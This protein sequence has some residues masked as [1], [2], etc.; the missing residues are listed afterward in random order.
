MRTSTRLMATALLFSLIVMGQ[1]CG[2]PA[3][4]SANKPITL[5]IW[6]TFENEDVLRD[7]M[8]A[9]STL[10]P[11]VSFDYRQK[12]SD[13]YK[14]SLLRAF[15]EGT[16]PDIFSIHNSWIGEYESLM[17][18]MPKTLKIPYTETKGTIKKEKVT[19]I[20]NEPTITLRQLKSEFVDVVTDD[21][22]RSYQATTNDEAQ[23]RI[24]ALP[25]SVDTLAL[26]YNKDLL[27]AAGIA[28]PPK[29]WDEFM[30]DAIKMSSVGTGDEIVQSGAAMGASRNVERAVDIL[31]LLMLQTGTRMTDDRGRAAFSQAIEDRSLPG[32][33][34]IR[35]YTNF[36]SPLP[37]AY[38][39]NASQPSS[40]EAFAS[41]KAAFFFGYSYHT[42]LI[43]NRAPKLRFGITQAPQTTGGKV[44][45]Y[46]NYW[47]EGVSKASK[48]QTWAWDF[49]QFAA[50]PEQAK[51]YLDVAGKPPAR[52]AMIGAQLENENLAPF[53]SQVLTAKSWYHGNDAGVME[54]ALLDAIDSVL[55]GIETENALRIAENK[56]NQTL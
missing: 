55:S 33:E 27:N 14:Q 13:E 11:N 9:Y 2:K 53:A 39:W 34:A 22:V 7:L 37:Q 52:R 44:V 45:N 8:T 16:G 4:E 3:A 26:F 54:Q 49:V 28:E 10:H 40:F 50:K 47:V 6:R 41:G 29:T 18:P 48:N 17:A 30:A 35:F 23:D 36:A 38:S 12:R 51:K 24:F 19:T 5:T 46:A 32:A 1:G 15:A 42:P 25:L 56:V 20:R 43:R 31:S 21:V